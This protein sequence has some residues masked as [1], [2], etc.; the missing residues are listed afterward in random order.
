MLYKNCER[1]VTMYK[2]KPERNPR[3]ALLLVI[4][5]SVFSC[6]GFCGSTFI[7]TYRLFAQLIAV[8]FL[9]MSIMIIVRYTLTEIEYTLTADSFSV[10]KIIGNKVTVLCSID[11][12]ST[13]ALVDKKTYAESKEFSD[14]TIRFNHCQNIK[15]QSFV[16]VYHLNK[17]KGMI[18]FEPNA[19][20]VKI[21]NEAIENSK[22]DD[23]ET[24]NNSDAKHLID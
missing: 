6:A 17:K 8:M 23:T 11:L 2:Y 22:K 10:S 9:V 21:M 14:V 13:I 24:K 3:Q 4:C 12:A 5:L 20:F 19:I 16:F 7:G 18:E 1:D 15:A